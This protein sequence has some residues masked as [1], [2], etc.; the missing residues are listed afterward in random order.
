MSFA[1]TVVA[2]GSVAPAELSGPVLLLLAAVAAAMAG[3]A[4]G[5][6]TGFLTIKA[7][8][9]AARSLRRL[10]LRPATKAPA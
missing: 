10:D 6:A 8:G 2:A 5:G 7:A 3:A 9:A 4:L 1:E